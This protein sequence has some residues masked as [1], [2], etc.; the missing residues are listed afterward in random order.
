MPAGPIDPRWPKLL[1]L[2]A[3]EFRS[4]LTVVSGYLNMLLKERVGPLTDQQRR[5]LEAAE[6][7]CGRL[8]ALLAEVSEL[9]ELE[10][11]TARFNRSALDVATLLADVI[12]Q[13]PELPDRTVTVAL[14]ADAVRR[15]SGDAVRLKSAFT[16][17]LSALRRELV[18]SDRLDV[19]VEPTDQAAPPAVRITIAEAVRMDEVRA[20]SPTELSVFDEWRGGN[21]LS[22]ATA[23]RVIEAH[24]GKLRG[25]GND[26]KTVAIITL[27]TT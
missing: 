10:A 3:H 2:T 4:P 14:A 8:S 22:L 26:G 25:A 5:L 18:T 24:G 9:S 7:S 15:V 6:K 17:I 21:G 1:S 19:R 23:R 27:P 13:L 11:R 20:I 16:G 12:A